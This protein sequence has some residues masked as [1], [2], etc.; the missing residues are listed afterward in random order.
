MNIKK[1]FPILDW[2]PNYKKEYL[3]NDITAGLTVG[4]MLIPQGMA[5]AMIAGLPPVYG[6]YAAITPQIIYA[7][8]GTSRQL[9]V[10]PVAMDSLLVAA[11]VS[12]IAQVGS[13]NYIALALLLAFM[14][15][16]IQLSFGLL[17]M[18]FLVNF[19][20]KPVISGFTSAAALIIGLSQ[21][22]HLVGVDLGRSSSIFE[23]LYQAG[24]RIAEFNWYA[25][26]VGFG[27]ILIIK[28]I[29]RL[30]PSIPGALAAVVIGILAVFGLGLH[31]YGVK[32]VGVV[33][34]GLPSFSIPAI[35]SP[36]LQEL[37]PIALAL[38]LIAFMEA[39]SVAKALHANHKGEYE[40]DANQ[41]LIGLGMGNIVGSFMGSY[42]TTGGFSR[43]AVSE[44]AGS[45]TNLAAIISAA[46]IALTL[47][48]LTSLFYYLP[49]AILA[50]VIM[51][52]VFGLIDTQY[53]RFLWKTKKE[54]FAM[55]LVA[56]IT[57][58]TVGIQQGIGV[59]VALSLIV[60]IYRSTKPHVA[61]LGKIP[62]TT[63][64]RNIDRFEE[65]EVQDDILAMRY[66]AQLYFANTTHFVDSV[67]NA[68]AA[69]P[70][71]VKLL[72]LDCSS[73]SS[74]D[75]T[76]LQALQELRKDLAQA[77]TTLY[78]SSVI[79][80][81]RDFLHKTGFTEEAGSHAFFLDV[82]TAINAYD[83]NSSADQKEKSSYA[84]QTGILK[85]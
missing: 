47:L 37:V 83:K 70:K 45:K 16:V 80:P 21:L 5:Y 63:E 35:D 79:G 14:M 74:I 10:G 17:R 38:S 27:G 72:V 50:S 24:S 43:S 33:P 1:F 46:L 51:V 28:N 2:L 19:L 12:A 44:Q 62:E 20:S 75:A 25:I 53:P 31:E 15:G 22:K 3:S 54:D 61:I 30:H 78:F 13:E 64:Y 52:A 69:K 4:V 32:I 49:N 59:G 73:I 76:A 48:F 8:F 57:T 68:I 85:P 81:V 26:A 42:P 66:D 40:L 71:E 34:D 58:L 7:I 23:I 6:L 77:G 36:H 41:E 29:K 65:L 60:M 39:I 67:K 9:A 11:G 56:F 55:L 82:Q 18:G 84:L